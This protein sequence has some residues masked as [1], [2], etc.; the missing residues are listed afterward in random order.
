MATS[1]EMRD[2]HF[3]LLV[4]DNLVRRLF[5]DPKKYCPYVTGGQMVAD[6]ALIRE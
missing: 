2:K 5:R 4:H 1:E 3:P 6:L